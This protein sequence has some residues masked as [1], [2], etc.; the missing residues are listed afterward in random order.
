MMMTSLFQYL[1]R[2]SFI[3]YL[4]KMNPKT[5]V[6]WIP[7]KFEETNSVCC[8][9]MKMNTFQFSSLLE[10]GTR[11]RPYGG[12]NAEL[13]DDDDE[14]NEEMPMARQGGGLPDEDEDLQMDPRQRNVN[15][16]PPS[17]SGQRRPRPVP[18]QRDNKED[19]DDF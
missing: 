12:M 2:L 6:E 15:R 4:V 1:E 11:G 10:N 13:S 16:R 5:R 8:I 3:S 19:D 7:E 14:D 9:P 17:A 18:R